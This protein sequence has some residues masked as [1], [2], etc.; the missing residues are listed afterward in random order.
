MIRV[1]GGSFLMGSEHQDYEQPIHEVQVSD[2]YLGQCPVTNAQYAAFLRAY[3]SDKVKSGEYSEQKMIVPHAW[4][5]DRLEGDWQAHPGF[6][7][8][9]VVNV[10]WYGAVTFC[11]W[12]S[13][14]AGKA[15][16]LPSE[17]EWEYAAR[18]GRHKSPFEYAGSHKLMEVGWYSKNSGGSTQPVGLLLPNALGLYDMSGNVWEWCADHWHRNYDGA[19]DDGKPWTTGGEADRRVVRGGSWSDLPDLCRVSLRSWDFADDR[20]S[21]QGFRV[22]RYG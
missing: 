6:E 2:F 4:G 7:N 16:R 5:I 18:G 11:D 20:L 21:F 13:E 15:Y 1:E 12:L 19:P 9:P 8:H 3:G 22:S 14:K 10:S 17:A